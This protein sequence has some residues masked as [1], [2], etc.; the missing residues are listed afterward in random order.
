MSTKGTGIDPKVD[1]VFKQ[2]CGDEETALV[3][4]D[5]VNAVVDF[6]QGKRTQGVTIKN[7]FVAKDYAEGKVPVLDVWAADD[8]GRQFILEMQQFVRGGFAKRLLYYWAGG[9]AEQLLKGARYELLQPTFLICFVNETLLHDASWHHCFVVYDKKNDTILCKDLEIHILELNKFNLLVEELKTPLQRWCYFFKHGASLDPA[10]LPATLAVPVIRQAMEVLV[11]ISQTEL[12]RHRYLE[13][14][15]ADRDAASLAADARVAQE[16]ARVAQENLKSAQEEV[17]L[18]QENL[19]S[20]QEEARL[21]Q[22][23]ARL[24]QEKARLAQEKGQRIGRIQLLQQIL[25]QPETAI[26]E[27]ATLPQADLIELEE[28]LKRQLSVRKQTNGTPPAD[29]T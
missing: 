4:V 19:K 8:P 14:Q 17:R 16:E 9:H 3:L 5:L 28:S 21:A 10:N 27:L 7:P 20:A 15:R 12:E 6:P 23:E 26:E 13:R 25:N 11:R 18:V 24:A 2:I 1:Y 29:K 22:E